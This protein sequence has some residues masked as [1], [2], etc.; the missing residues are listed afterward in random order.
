MNDTNKP[1]G[2]HDNPIRYER[3]KNDDPERQAK[4]AA[5]RDQFEKDAQSGKVLCLSDLMCSHGM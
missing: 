1:V 5:Q 4:L 2:T 3:I